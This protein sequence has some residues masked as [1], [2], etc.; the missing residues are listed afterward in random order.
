MGGGGNCTGSVCAESGDRH[1][2]AVWALTE[3][4]ARALQR[5]QPF[6]KQNET[7]VFAVSGVR[8]LGA[9]KCFGH[10]H[11]RFRAEAG[12]NQFNTVAFG[13]AS[14]AIPE[15][16]FEMAGH[17]EIDDFNDKPCFRALAWR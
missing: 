11:I 2:V 1:A 16:S 6:G 4:L 14:E 5:L 7:P 8:V 9:P 3:E 12:P 13:L 15:G 10:N 17:W